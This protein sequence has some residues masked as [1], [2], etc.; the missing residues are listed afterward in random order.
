MP[1]AEGTE[2]APEHWKG[3]EYTPF[4]MHGV[5]S[6]EVMGGGLAGSRDGTTTQRDLCPRVN[7]DFFSQW[8]VSRC[9]RLLQRCGTVGAIAANRSLDGEVDDGERGAWM[10]PDRWGLTIDGLRW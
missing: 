4:G 7:G 10:V 6:W 3:P 5:N 9:R 2:A 1:K 8:D